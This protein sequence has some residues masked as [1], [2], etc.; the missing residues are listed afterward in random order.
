MERSKFI[1]EIEPIKDE[2]IVYCDEVGIDNNITVLRGWSEK[3]KRSYAEQI[4]YK[5]ERVSM[6]AAYTR[7]SKKLIAPIE[8][9]GYTDTK[10]FNYWIEN[11]L[12]PNLKE[13][14]FVIMDNA[15]F[16]KSPRVKELIEQAKCHLIYLPPYSPDLNPI[17]HCW[18]NFKNYLRK[19]IKKFSNIQ[20]AISEALIRTFPG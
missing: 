1:K 19:I 5:T 20:D 17:E 8:Y 2:N 3:G 4:G 10:L 9:K 15:S 11:H 12:C 6:I 7:G 13:G 18:G 16:H 14:Q